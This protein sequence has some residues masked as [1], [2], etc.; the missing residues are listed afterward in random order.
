MILGFLDINIENLATHE[1]GHVLGIDHTDI[2]GNIMWYQ[3]GHLK[4][5]R[6]KLGDDDIRAAQALYGMV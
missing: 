3:V 6:V 5:N 2:W 1:I 4:P